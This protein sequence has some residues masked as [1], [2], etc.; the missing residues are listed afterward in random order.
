MAQDRVPKDI[1]HVM[2]VVGEGKRMDER[3]EV[4]DADAERD[5]EEGPYESVSSRGGQGKDRYDGR[6]EEGE[7]KKGYERPEVE[8]LCQ[9]DGRDVIRFIT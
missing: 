1:E 4:H 5:G 7:G 9:M 3:V 2:P 6:K 8:N